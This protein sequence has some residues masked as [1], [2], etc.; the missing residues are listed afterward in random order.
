MDAASICT[1]DVITCRRDTTLLEAARLMRDRHV[2][3]LIVI[4]GT[5]SEASP[6]GMLTDRDVVLA[7]VA[8]G[9]D[10]STLFVGE[11]MSEPAVLA[12][13]WESPWDVA[14]RMRLQGVRRMPVIGKSGELVGVIAFDDL[15][16]AASHLVSSLCLA[17]E[18]Q[19]YF[20]EKRRT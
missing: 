5:A 3:D 6:V 10:P 19:P 15:L 4:E 2:G 13:A 8:A 11:V 14:G 12:Y 1:R 18:R 9:V 20:E 16:E 17:A 7:V